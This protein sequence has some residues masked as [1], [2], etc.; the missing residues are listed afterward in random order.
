M[1]KASRNSSVRS[2]WAFVASFLFFAL[3]ASQAGD[4]K[5]AE[6][7][8]SKLSLS[9]TGAT[10]NM[11]FNTSEGNFPTFNVAA[12]EGFQIAL[13]V[14]KTIVGKAI[15]IR[16]DDGGVIKGSENGTFG[17]IS[18]G[19]EGLLKFNYFLGGTTGRYTLKIIAPGYMQVLEFWV[20]QPRPQASPGP[21][22][23][24]KS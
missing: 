4:L 11:S 8:I 23:P 14:P 9:S 15:Q 1:I 12:K 6:E 10:G 22:P 2:Y 18:Q 20:G 21:V 16:A 19:D 5:T 3:V 24:K 7:F 17:A 13:T